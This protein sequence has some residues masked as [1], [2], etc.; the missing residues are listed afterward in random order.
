MG[1]RIFGETRRTDHLQLY[2]GRN[3]CELAFFV[4]VSSVI[5][6]ILWLR[7]LDQADDS[8]MLFSPYTIKFLY[9]NYRQ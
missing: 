9:C 7:V 1:H 4:L 5:V 3:C 8:V 2:S 6:F